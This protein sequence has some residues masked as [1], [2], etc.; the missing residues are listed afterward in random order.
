MRPKHRNRRLGIIAVCAAALLV[1]GI[2]LVKAIS[3]GTRYFY[4]PSE[5]AAPGFVPKSENYRIG[6][7]VV[8]GSVEKVDSLTIAFSVIDIDEGGP[9]ATELN[10][11]M[12]VAVRYTGVVPDLFQEGKGVVVGGQMTGSVF[13]ADEVLA[14]HDENY[15]PKKN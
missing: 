2:L 8:P 3:S 11:D 6:G 5:V 10:A 1:G 12:S 4:D 14:K 9:S 15:Q 7:L 13:I